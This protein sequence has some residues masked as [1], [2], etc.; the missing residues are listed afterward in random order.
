MAVNRGRMTTDK[1][2]CIR[3]TRPYVAYTDHYSPLF[4]EA[5]LHRHTAGSCHK[6]EPSSLDGRPSILGIGFLVELFS[7]LLQF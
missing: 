4:G 2:R 5:C 3:T 1:I 7:D 6:S